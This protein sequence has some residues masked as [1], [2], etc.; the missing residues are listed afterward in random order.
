MSCEKRI[1]SHAHFRCKGEQHNLREK[2]R[3][4]NCLLSSFLFFHSL[5]VVKLLLRASHKKANVQAKEKN[6][7]SGLPVSFFNSF[8]HTNNREDSAVP[9]ETFFYAAFHFSGNNTKIKFLYTRLDS[10]K[11]KDEAYVNGREVKRYEEEFLL[12]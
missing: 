7:N 2:K 1:F 11:K 6:N 12:C 8:I 10:F 3:D 9:F 5:M 4:K